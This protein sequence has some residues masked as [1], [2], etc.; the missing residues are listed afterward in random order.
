MQL[1]HI[2]SL[3]SGS[4]SFLHCASR[5]HQLQRQLAME[6]FVFSNRS[7]QA[8]FL[9]SV[10]RLDGRLR[11]LLHQEGYSDPY[12]PTG[13]TEPVETEAARKQ[14][15]EARAFFLEAEATR[16]EQES[17]LMLAN[18]DRSLAQFAQ[19]LRRPSPWLL[20]AIREE[21]CEPSFLQTLD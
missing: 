20:A 17:L 12:A 9:A 2:Q 7:E 14:R 21:E 11:L 5:L 1:M 6:G 4:I 18:D 13:P 19:A 10:N 16:E 3:G 15:W 8:S